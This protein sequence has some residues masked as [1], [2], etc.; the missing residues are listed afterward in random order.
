[1]CSVI[2]ASDAI[3]REAIRIRNGRG[4]TAQCYLVSLSTEGRLAIAN[5]LERLADA[6]DQGV[7]SPGYSGFIL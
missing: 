6:H 7:D 3:R 2:T 5:W 1:M 4:E